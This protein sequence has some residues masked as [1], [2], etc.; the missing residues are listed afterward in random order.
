VIRLTRRYRFSAAHRLHAPAL[1][2]ADNGALY[3]KCNNPFGHGHDYVLE[4]SVRGPLDPATGRAADV[5]ALDSLVRREVLE[6]L[7]HQDL[8][9]G[10]PAFAAAIPTAENIAIEIRARLARQWPRAFPGEWPR[11]DRI[12]IYETKRNRFDLYG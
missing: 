11:L 8:N 1:S 10:V 2:E 3:G 9:S 4:V 12:R 6:P 7:D 5:G